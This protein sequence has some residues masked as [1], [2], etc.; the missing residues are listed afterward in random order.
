MRTLTR[1]LAV[2]LTVL[3]LFTLAACG[4][5][6]A[7]TLGDIPAYPG[8]TELK[9]GESN[10]GDTL[11]NNNQ[12]DAAMRGQVGV[13]GKTEQKGFNLPKDAKWDQIKGFYD[14]KLKASGW[15]TN[16]LVGGIM[17]QANQG[18]TLFQT[19]NWQKGTQ[20]VTVLMVTSPT[21]ADE[22]QLIISLSSQ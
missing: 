5:S 6:A 22:K 11:A 7:A 15:G 3:T 16:S 2:V 19:S 12:A 1:L 4:G 21:N 10:L 18:N 20:N 14:E 8:A 17:D 13:G 9:P